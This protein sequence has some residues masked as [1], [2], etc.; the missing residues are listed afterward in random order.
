MI[1]ERDSKFPCFVFDL[2]ISVLCIAF[3][4][5][6]HI[7]ISIKKN[8]ETAEADHSKILWCAHA[9]AQVSFCM[10]PFLSPLF[11]PLPPPQLG[12]T[13]L[14]CHPQAYFWS[15]LIHP[16]LLFICPWPRSLVFSAIIYELWQENLLT[17]K[18][19]K[20]SDPSWILTEKKD[21]QEEPD[22]P[23]EKPICRSGSN[24]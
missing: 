9:F 16:T 14:F 4:W 19:S 20:I 23:L 12:W 8:Q 11:R 15:L 3:F 10:E 22:L 17:G 1:I 6:I 21:H 5:K 24:S 13:F 18:Q 2:Q 7:Q